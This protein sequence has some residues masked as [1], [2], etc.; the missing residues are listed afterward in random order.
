LG[1]DLGAD[2]VT[3]NDEDDSDG[4]PNGLQNFAVLTF[5]RSGGGQVV[6]EG[7]LQSSPGFYTLQFFLCGEADPSGFG[8]GELF[9]GTTAVMV[10]DEEG[11]T[12]FFKAGFA[13]PPNAPQEFLVS[14]ITLNEDRQT[15]EFSGAIAAVEGGTELFVTN[16]ADSGP[17]SLRQAIFDAN[18]DADVNTIIFALANPVQAIS[19]E[20]FSVE[21]PVIID[22]FT[23]NG[24]TPNTIASPTDARLQVEIDG[25][26]ASAGSVGFVVSAPGTVIRGLSIHSFPAGAIRSQDADELRIEGN[27]I[28]LDRSGV[29]TPGNGGSGVVTVGNDTEVVIGGESPAQRNIISGS[30][31]F[32]IVASGTPALILNNIIGGNALGTQGSGNGVG[33]IRVAA[34]GSVVGSDDPLLGNEIRD[35]GGAGIEVLN[36]SGTEILVNSI[37]D[38]AGVGIDLDPFDSPGVTPNDGPDDADNGANA[39]QDFPEL[40]AANFDNGIL[41][42]AGI[43]RVPQATIDAP[44]TIRIFAAAACDESGHGEG[45][46]FVGAADVEL[47]GNAEGFAFELPVSGLPGPV[48]TATA[49]DRTLRNTSEFSEC[50]PSAPPP[51]TCGDA[52]GEGNISAADAFLAL[53]AAVGTGT[54]ELCRCDVNDSG[55]ITAPDALLVLRAAVGQAV[56][57]A[58]PGCP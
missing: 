49:T 47:S 11:T 35:N 38:N 51:S 13:L 25:S 41:E 2:G 34:N 33:G 39:R 40:F 6:V 9:L 28:G 22:G 56:L 8:E 50:F 45:A 53:A 4:G 29:E 26:P 3:A 31:N 43:L 14:S 5:A 7:H 12:A 27:Y 44:Y 19:S 30:L 23:Q 37:F 46:T 15:S 24:S 57:L 21:H 20:G 52:T 55:G 58:C 18:Q 16:S 17:G 36:S 42:V 48:F 10:P 32:G 1:I 54:C